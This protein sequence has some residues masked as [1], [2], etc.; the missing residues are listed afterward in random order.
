[1][2]VEHRNHLQ[3]RSLGTHKKIVEKPNL[4]LI[5]FNKNGLIHY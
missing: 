5:I 2:G 1:M 4:T 3:C